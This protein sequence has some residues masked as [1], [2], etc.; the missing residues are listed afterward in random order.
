MDDIYSDEC[1]I[2]LDCLDTLDSLDSLSNK[3]L[4]CK[5]KYHTYCINMWLKLNNNCPLC[6]YSISNNYKCRDGRN[7]LFK[8]KITLNDDHVLFTHIFYK[9]K[10]DYKKIKSIQSNSVF[11]YINYIEHNAIT[12]KKFIF[13]NET[14]CENFFKSMQNKFYLLV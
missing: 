4:P 13:K 12:S 7:T 11:F 9:R 10:Y 2:C 14:I 1:P 3:V 5:H 8:Y 6:R